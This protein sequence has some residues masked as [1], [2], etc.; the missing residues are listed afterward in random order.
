MGNT[1]ASCASD[2]S[3][4]RGDLLEYSVV[5]TDRA[6]NLMSSPFQQVMKDISSAMK[7]VYNA[8]SVAIIPGSGTYAMEACAREFGSGGKCLVI[9]NGYFSFRW[10][11]I[12]NCGKFATHT[13][14]FGGVTETPNWEHVI[15]ARAVEGQTGDSIQFQ[16]TDIKI[17]CEQILR[18]KPKAVFAPH[19]ETSTGMILSDDDVRQLADA[20]HEVGGIFILDCIA[21]GTIWVDMKKTGVD[22]LISAPQKGWSGPACCGLVML[23]ELAVKHIKSDQQTNVGKSFSVNLSKW[24]NVMETYEGGGFK[25]YTTLPTDALT[26]FR[27][28][29]KETQAFGFNKAKESLFELGKRVREEM[30]KRNFP[31]VAASKYAS[32]G[33]VVLYNNALKGKNM[34]GEF[35][36][37]GLQIAGGV[38]FMLN[39]DKEHHLDPRERCFRLGLFGLDKI[40]NIDRTVQRLCNAVDKMINDASN[41]SNGS[42]KM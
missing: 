37:N 4:P 32:P 6:V 17:A 30:L 39:E 1:T 2:K 22:A 29:I 19:V 33:V 16:P 5:Y 10:T 15:P 20:T 42:S 13:D 3:N 7:E 21:S 40:Q 28:V 27:D 26:Q 9:R 8:N 25:Y 14:P 34:A 11:D 38:P 23:S 41:S 31:S 18:E 24:L 36:K 12:F 35:K